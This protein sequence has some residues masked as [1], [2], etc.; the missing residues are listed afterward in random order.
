M[1][2]FKVDAKS[3]DYPTVISFSSVSTEKGR[4][5]PYSALLEGSYNL[6]FVNDRDNM[7]YQHGIDGLDGTSQG[8]ATALVSEARRIGNGRVVTLGSSMG[9]FGAVLFASLGGADGCLAFGVETLLNL[10]GSR[11]LRFISKTAGVRYPD[12]RDIITAATHLV[13]SEEDETDLYCALRVLDHPLIT[14]QSIRG[15]DHPGIQIITPLHKLIE[16]FA[17]TG[18]APLPSDRIGGVLRSR[19]L[20]SRLFEASMIA[21]AS[22]DEKALPILSRLATEGAHFLPDQRLAE[23]YKRNND[24]PRALLHWRRVLELEP[25]SYNALTSLGSW[26]KQPVEAS[27]ELLRRS[28]K[29]NP[30][31]GPT[32][33]HL[34]KM[35]LKM[36]HEQLAEQNFRQALKVTPAL[37]AAQLELDKL[38]VEHPRA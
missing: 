6:I 21:S 13:V 17:Y 37:S 23:I 20:V 4:F 16:T 18:C 34:G 15:I 2:Y 25:L 12:L 1:T 8:A 33:L 35:Y 9:G 26:T 3:R 19:D 10:P 14:A 28:A 30:Y 29:I 32:F 7:W 11:S 27:I 31:H 38:L 22:G 36:G 5:K 24:Y